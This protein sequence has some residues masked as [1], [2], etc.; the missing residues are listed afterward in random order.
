MKEL[1]GNSALFVEKGD[2]LWC[3]L[4]YHAVILGLPEKIAGL[5]DEIPKLASR[6]K[7]S[8]GSKKAAELSPHTI[9][10]GMTF[11]YEKGEVNALSPELRRQLVA[12]WTLGA[13]LMPKA[14]N[15]LAKV[16][17]WLS[18]VQPPPPSAEHE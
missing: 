10:M 15:K 13:P 17:E 16:D 12:N 8:H 7:Q 4:G 11:C 1:E 2:S 3:P 18:V 14:L 5:E 9:T 6:G